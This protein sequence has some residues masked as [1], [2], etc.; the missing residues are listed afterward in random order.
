[1]RVS[2]L[3]VALLCGLAACSENGSE[4]IGTGTSTGIAASATAS[5]ADCELTHGEPPQGTPS[6]GTQDSSIELGPGPSIT[7]EE[8]AREARR[9]QGTPLVLS[10]TVYTEGC[11]SPAAGAVINVW[12]TD[13]RGIY[14][15]G[16]QRGNLRC[17]YLQGTLETDASGSYTIETVKPGHYSD[18]GTPPPAHIHMEVFHEGSGLL[19]EVFFAGD[20]YLPAGELEGEVIT[21]RRAPGPAGQRLLGR[22][23]IVLP[24]EPG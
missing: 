16:E 11:G 20:R 2:L 10:G 3:V 1:M 5:V 12:Q 18:G 22:F 7:K 9:P 13:A 15:P 17:C 14:G 24:G 23:D 21:L 4:G 6:S 8:A 19:T